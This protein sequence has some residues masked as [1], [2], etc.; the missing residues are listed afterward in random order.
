MVQKHWG[1]ATNS[2]SCAWMRQVSG[3]ERPGVQ[4]LFV[5]LGLVLIGV[6]ASEAVALRRA[7]TQ[8]EGLR[9][10]DL[11]AR[12]EQVRLQ[13]QV[14]REQSARESLSLQLARH[15]G[16]GT[17]AVQPTLTL[18]PLVKRGAQ[19]PDSTVVKPA[20]NQLIQ[21]RLLLPAAAKAEAP[22]YRIAVRLWSG[23]DAVWSRGGLTI[24]TVEN[25]RMV[26]AFISGDVL[27][28]GAYEIALTTDA[29]DKST[30]VAAYELGVGA[31][32]RR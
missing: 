29:A 32:V 23:G 9:A 2:I 14:A 5:A 25:T 11:N 4:W 19:P 3:F 21:L 6:A 13:A 26:T 8:I 22:Q 24:S 18:S 16:T 17:P 30:D 15:A 28:P 10:A 20:D 7:H 27:S 12:I 31:P 1:K